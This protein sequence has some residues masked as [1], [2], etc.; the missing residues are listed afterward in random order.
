MLFFSLFASL[1]SADPLESNY[2]NDSAATR[3]LLLP[4]AQTLK[5]GDLT[6]SL[7]ELFF[8]NA[9]YGIT[10][11]ISMQ[12]TTLLPIFPVGFGGQ[13]TA[14]FKL[15]DQ[16]KLNL[17]VEPSALIL[18]GDGGF[19]TVFGGGVIADYV[20][21]DAGRFI[22]TGSL[23]T[24]TL[25]G[26]NSVDADV[27]ISDGVLGIAGLGTQILLAKNFK[28]MGEIFVP[29]GFYNGEASIAQEVTSLNLGFR[30]MGEYTWDF[31]VIRPFNV[32]EGWFILPYLTVT[33]RFDLVSKIDQAK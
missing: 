29:I 27:G 26:V 22:F 23:N 10:D 11:T 5:K 19:T 28:I 16:E 15:L 33:R 9:N 6:L 31:S 14:R 17:S 8:I 32:N 24:Q 4:T 1:A 18:S 21:D 3:G 12:F 2:L 30:R 7:I 13:L 25:A 20:A